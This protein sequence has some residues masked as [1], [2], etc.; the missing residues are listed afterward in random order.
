MN[1]VVT[2]ACSYLGICLFL[3]SLLFAASQTG[4]GSLSME[5]QLELLNAHNYFRG[6]VDPTASNMQIMVSITV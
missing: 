3:H 4:T 6:M 1:V 2:Q 5:A